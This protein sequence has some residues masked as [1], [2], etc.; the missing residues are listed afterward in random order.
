[1]TAQVCSDME[2]F[3][4]VEQKTKTVLGAFLKARGL[5]IAALTVVKDSSWKQKPGGQASSESA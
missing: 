5:P 3:K 2:D 4:W 1:M